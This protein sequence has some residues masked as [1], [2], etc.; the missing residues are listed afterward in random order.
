MRVTNG[1]AATQKIARYAVSLHYEDLPPSLIDL[2]KQCIL[3]TLGVSIG[4]SGLAPEA[5]IA[6]EFIRDMAG[7]PESTI[8]GFGTKAP[9]PYAALV[10]GG[11]GHMLDYD[12]AG[13]GHVSIATLPVA[14]AL[15]E[16]KGGVSG[17]ELLTAMAC[18]T[19]VM[20]RID[21]SVPIPE[22]TAAE[23]WFATQLLGYIAG[24]IAGGRVLGLDQDQM[25]NAI[26]I[27]FNQLSGT[28]QMAEGSSTHMRSMQAGFSGQGATV[29]AQLA[30]KGMIGDKEVFEGKH[31]LYKTYIRTSD[32][33]W[34]V[35]V[36]ELGKRFPLFDTHVFKVWPACALTRAP[37]AA[38]L[39]LRMKHNLQPSEVEQ[40]VIVGGHSNT[41]QLCEPLIQKCRPTISIDGKFSIPYTAAVMMMYGNVTMKDYSLA[42]L[43]NPDVL[44]M[45]RRVVY[46]PC[47]REEERT[48][49]PEVEILKKDGTLLHCKV[50]SV[51]GDP[52]SPVDWSLLEAKFRDCVSFS[53]MPITAD[54][55][56]RVIGM[57]RN[58]EQLDDATELLK[59][60]H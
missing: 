44:D 55:I 26:G 8:L 51:P 36:G 30:A 24:A 5:H 14:L 10:N 49:Y 47:A 29:S 13:N 45:A 38:I 59:T 43:N 20:A 6:H 52:K 31:G 54:R 56:D 48:A 18:G 33:N 35:L 17:K 37:N 28:R 4:A 34:E 12:D 19:D 32:P 7:K 53:A 1:T 41:Q 40:I 27:G 60:L 2:L 39:E 42:N 3:D 16:H 25:E 22:W 58:L 23:G 11:L 57:I 50:A 46:R 21:L 9:A 15:A